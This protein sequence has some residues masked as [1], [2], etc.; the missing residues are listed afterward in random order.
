MI[1]NEVS[2]Y[3]WAHQHQI[4]IFVTFEKLLRLFYELCIQILEI[5]N[6]SIFNM[7]TYQG[8]HIRIEYR[9]EIASS[10]LHLIQQETGD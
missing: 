2:S 4:I 5:F 3:P 6:M 1:L 10:T 7:S 9:W 8:D